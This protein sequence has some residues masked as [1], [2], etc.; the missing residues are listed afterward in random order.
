MVAGFYGG[1]VRA[2]LVNAYREATGGRAGTIQDFWLGQ[3][4]IALGVAIFAGQIDV[5]GAGNYI[6]SNV[7]GR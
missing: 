4:G 7:R 6:R 3:S 5:S 1:A 2:T